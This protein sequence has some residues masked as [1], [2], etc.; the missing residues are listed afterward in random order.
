M[1]DIKRE[2]RWER[3]H[4]NGWIAVATSW[5][6]GYGCTAYPN[7][8]FQRPN[9]AS[10]GIPELVLAQQLADDRVPPHDC[11]CPPWSELGSSGSSSLIPVNAGDTGLPRRR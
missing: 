7:L 4:S 3:S 6:D 5:R 1:P 2:N 9:W 11:E 8:S 10:Y